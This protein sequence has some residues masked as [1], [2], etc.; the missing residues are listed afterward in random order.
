MVEEGSEAAVAARRE[1]VMER[2]IAEK[3]ARLAALPKRVPLEDLLQHRHCVGCGLPVTRYAPAGATFDLGTSTEHRCPEDPGE[4]ASCACGAALLLFTSGKCVE[5][6]SGTPH[7]CPWDDGLGVSS[8]I[9]QD[10]TR[11]RLEAPERPT[12]S[13]RPGVLEIE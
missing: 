6:P 7:D 8:L 3:D 12:Q 11:R 4:V 10:V 13:R 9:G 2:M 1:Q 5:W